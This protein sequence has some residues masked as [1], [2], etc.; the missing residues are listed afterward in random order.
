VI[1]KA[2]KRI[3]NSDKICSSY[4]D[5]YFGITFFGTHCILLLYY[6]VCHLIQSAFSLK[7]QGFSTVARLNNTAP[8][9]TE[10]KAMS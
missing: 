5:F 2:A 1:I 4:Y 8:A 7:L 10:K 3:L 9:Q 6:A